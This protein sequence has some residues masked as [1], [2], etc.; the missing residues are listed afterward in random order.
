MQSL[1][2][3]LLEMIGKCIALDNADEDCETVRRSSLHAL[4]LSC[5]K[6][7]QIFEPLLYY[8]LDLGFLH[9]LNTARVNLIIRLWRNPEIA[10]WVRSL[11]L[12]WS[13]GEPIPLDDA[14]H[15]DYE[16]IVY[17][18]S[19]VLD[20]LF[21]PEDFTKL[22]WRHSLLEDWSLEAWLGLLFV[23]LTHLE[24]IEFD[25]Y[26]TASRFCDILYKAA[27]REKPFHEDPPFPFLRKVVANCGEEGH[28]IHERFITP[29]FY[30]P[31]VQSVTGRA[32]WAA[33]RQDDEHHKR[34]FELPPT[35]GPVRFISFEQVWRCTGMVNWLNACREL[36]HFSVEA[37]VPIDSMD[38]GDPFNTRDLY[39]A[40]LPFKKTLKSL[41]IR[42]DWHYN[43]CLDMNSGLGASQDNFPFQSFQEFSAL[44]HLTVRHAHLLRVSPDSP[45]EE[46]SL[47]RLVDRLPRSLQIFVIQ[48]VLRDSSRLISELL[49]VVQNQCLF[50]H[51]KRLELIDKYADDPPPSED[52]S[53]DWVSSTIDEQVNIDLESIT[54]LARECDARGIDLV[55]DMGEDTESETVSETESE[56]EIETESEA[57]NAWH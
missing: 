20:V 19:R 15:E 28:G 46:S 26:G 6:F 34:A 44:E 48:D 49:V 56:T 32:L 54:I 3:E 27:R 55:W 57:E 17:F 29:F 53:S 14:S 37:S 2:A 33:N 23:P 21:T 52:E 40:L 4:T 43:Y 47:G 16:R 24:S 13:S 41:S 31:N 7:H 10:N 50:P 36:E 8:H 5:R 45:V 38:I 9:P 51:L 30:L 18:V 1:P 11:R 22:M 42:Y 25:N 39:Q 35:S 12:Y